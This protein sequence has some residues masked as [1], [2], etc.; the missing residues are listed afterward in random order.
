MKYRLAVVALLMLCTTG[1]MSI[2]QAGIYTMRWE[3]EGRRPI[4]SSATLALV[5]QRSWIKRCISGEDW[6]MYVDGPPGGTRYD[7]T[8]KIRWGAFNGTCKLQT[9]T[10]PAVMKLRGSVKSE[11]SAEGEFDLR[12]PDGATKGTWRIT[13]SWDTGPP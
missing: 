13:P 10:G 9:R 7:I 2:G 12:T 1:C 11:T 4:Y 8:G 5:K 6:V 3:P